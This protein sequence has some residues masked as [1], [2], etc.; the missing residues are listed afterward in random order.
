MP[1]PIRKPMRPMNEMLRIFAQQAEE[2]MLANNLRVQRIWPTEVYPGWAAENAERE[3]RGQ[4]HSTGEGERSF[5]FVVTNDSPF[6]AE[7]EMTFLSYMRYVD[8]GVGKGVP[9]EDVERA[10]KA[11][12]KR[13]YD[14]WIG[15]VKRVSRPHALMEARHVLRRMRDF[16]V[17]FYGY[18]GTGFVINTFDFEGDGEIRMEM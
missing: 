10:K 1:T 17:D 18:E 6:E 2:T 15:H 16:A 9:V 14:K 13:R 11:H 5:K 7:I 8:L 12:F 3:R 4:S